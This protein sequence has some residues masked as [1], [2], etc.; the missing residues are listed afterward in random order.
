MS[1]RGR[2]SRLEPYFFWNTIGSPARGMSLGFLCGCIDFGAGHRLLL[3]YVHV[4]PRRPAATRSRRALVL[5]LRECE[6][7]YIRPSLARYLLGVGP[8]GRLPKV[9]WLESAEPGNARTKAAPFVVDDLPFLLQDH[10][11][12]LAV[13]DGETGRRVYDWIYLQQWP[14]YVPRPLNLDKTRPRKASVP[15]RR[16]P[17]RS[18]SRK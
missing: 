6:R 15:G 17:A 18:A 4:R 14:E 10:R 2:V 13:G 11:S 12:L 9:M 3:E 5:R 16:R 7:N 8:K 1:A